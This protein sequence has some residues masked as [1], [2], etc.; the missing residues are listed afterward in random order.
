M[1]VL[2]GEGGSLEP[3][4]TKV[5]LCELMEALGTL[6]GEDGVSAVSALPLVGD[7]PPPPWVMKE[8]LLAI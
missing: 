5:P 2:I 6:H 7:A 1:P 4:Y 3:L 8:S